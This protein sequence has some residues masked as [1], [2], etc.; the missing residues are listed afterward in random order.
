MTQRYLAWPSMATR[1][2]ATIPKL[3]P[4][5][6]TLLAH[7]HPAIFWKATAYPALSEIY[8][9]TESA[10]LRDAKLGPP[11]ESPILILTFFGLNQ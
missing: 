8:K 11:R 6:T 9:V 2:E 3:A 10:V 5:P 1:R 7:F 4:A